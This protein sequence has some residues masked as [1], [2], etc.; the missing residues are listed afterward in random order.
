MASEP[1]EWNLH[2]MWKEWELHTLSH[3]NLFTETINIF[4][5][6]FNVNSLSIVHALWIYSSKK[7]FPSFAWL[8]SESFTDSL[9]SHLCRVFPLCC[10]IC[11]VLTRV[12]T[13]N[14]ACHCWRKKRWILKYDEWFNI[15]YS[16]MS[17]ILVAFYSLFD[18]STLLSIYKGY[19]VTWFNLIRIIGLK[20]I[21]PYME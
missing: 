21:K 15:H 7:Y 20:T 5:L 16:N 17:A 11:L 1:N 12:K 13:K 4:R 14:W 10:F 18:L 9:Y 8:K 6:R 19:S 2:G 3:A